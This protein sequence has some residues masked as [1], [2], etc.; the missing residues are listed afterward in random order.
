MDALADALDDSALQIATLVRSEREFSA[1]ASHQL[2]SPPTAMMDNALAHGRGDVHVEV[3]MDADTVEIEVRDRG[4]I[5]DTDPA[6]AN[7]EAGRG[8]GFSSP[9]TCF[10][11]TVERSC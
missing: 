2:R 4:W 11:A 10:A 9:T 1:N 8:V 6:T 5:D 7:P 3:R